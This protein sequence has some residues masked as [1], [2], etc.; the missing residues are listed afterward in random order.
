MGS[1]AL[2]PAAQ[3]QIDFL[4]R[5]KANQYYFYSE[6]SIEFK[7]HPLLNPT[8]RFTQDQVRR[9]VAYARER[10][11]DIKLGYMGGSQ[12]PRYIQYCSAAA[13]GPSAEPGAYM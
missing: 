10:L 6:A 4:A 5:W 13:S 9:I 11:S 7:G 1:L 8:A 3:Q 2:G 12:A